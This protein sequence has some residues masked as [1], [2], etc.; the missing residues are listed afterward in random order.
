[1]DAFHQETNALVPTKNPNYDGTSRDLPETTAQAYFADAGL[2]PNTPQTFLLTDPDGDSRRNEDEFLQQTKPSIADAPV[3]TTWLYDNGSF[4]ETR[5]GLPAN[6]VQSSFEILDADGNVA[7]TPSSGLTLD[8]Q[9]G[10]FYVYRPT[11]PQPGANP[12]DLSPSVVRPVPGPSTP[13]A[14]DPADFPRLSIGSGAG[15]IHFN[16]KDQ[17]G[18]RLYKSTNLTEW[19]LWEDFGVVFGNHDVTVPLNPAREREFYKLEVYQP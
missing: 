12:A 7:F 3:A 6:V 2:A 4:L 8:G 15:S 16:L 11:N 19:K 14:I 5:F 17:I 18:H 1:M 9:Y 10:P 13:P